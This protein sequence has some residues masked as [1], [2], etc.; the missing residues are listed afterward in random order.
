M[1]G[2]GAPALT[3]TPTATFASGVRLFTITLPDASTSGKGRWMTG[4]SK[5]PPSATCFFEPSPD[6]NVAFTLLPL[7]LSKR[8]SKTSSAALAP[9]GAISVISSTAFALQERLKSRVQRRGRK[10]RYFMLGLPFE[11][12]DVKGD[13]FSGGGNCRHRPSHETGML[14]NL[15]AARH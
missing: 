14:S 3:A 9:P 5:S 13:G 6:V 1:S 2:L 8:G 4:T 15:Q 7:L 10:Y 12:Y 11:L